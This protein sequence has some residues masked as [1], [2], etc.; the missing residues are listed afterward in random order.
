LL[1]DVV[2]DQNLVIG[3]DVRY[4]LEKQYPLNNLVRMFYFAH[5]FFPENFVKPLVSP[6][7]G[8]FGMNE[9]L[10]DAGYSLRS[11]W[12]KTAMTCSFP[13]MKRLPSYVKAD[14]GFRQEWDQ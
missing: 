10:V 5:R 11:T 3:G 4:P 13:F 8:H 9:I 7:F 1:L 12:F 2:A 14:R 6:V